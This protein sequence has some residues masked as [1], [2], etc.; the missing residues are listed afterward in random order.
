MQTVFVER[1]GNL[2]ATPG[3]RAVL[4][5]EA[6]LAIGQERA[7]LGEHDEQQAIQQ[8][9]CLTGKMTKIEM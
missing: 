3:E 9:L 5:V 6:V 2:L 8:E 4:S 7:I 1:L